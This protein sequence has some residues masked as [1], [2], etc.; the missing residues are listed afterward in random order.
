MF[1]LYLY[2]AKKTCLAC[3]PVREERGKIGLTYPMKSNKI[4]VV[5]VKITAFAAC[6][7]RGI[8]L[9][10]FSSS[11][12]FYLAP[13]IC[14]KIIA[15][16]R[17]ARSAKWQPV[18]ASFCTFAQQP[19]KKRSFFLHLFGGEINRECV[20]RSYVVGTEKDPSSHL[21]KRI[22]REKMRFYDG[23]PSR[24]EEYA[25]EFQKCAEI[26]VLP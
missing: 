2:R 6:C 20:T 19:C 11:Q 17:F 25:R 21:F 5:T 4:Q 9:I 15:P 3:A 26:N 23:T 7:T 10:S 13:D 12:P 24:G 14:P 18:V 1:T 22:P 16:P 8:L